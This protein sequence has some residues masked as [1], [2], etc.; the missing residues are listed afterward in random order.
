MNSV[1]QIEGLSPPNKCSLL[2][3]PQEHSQ[4]SAAQLCQSE[5]DHVG[6][7]HQATWGPAS[8][9]SSVLLKGSERRGD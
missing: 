3:H 5:A 9:P 2:Q 6:S 7:V 1:R 8:S 4:S